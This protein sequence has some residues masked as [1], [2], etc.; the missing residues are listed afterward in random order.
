MTI[1]SHDALITE[2]TIP[3]NHLDNFIWRIICFNSIGSVGWK[4]WKAAEM[5]ENADLGGTNYLKFVLEVPPLHFA[6]R[7]A[8][9]S[10]CSSKQISSQHAYEGYVVAPRNIIIWPIL[11]ISAY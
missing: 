10:T 9:T 7:S 8:P 2:S 11:A 6:A 4:H 1:L 3:Y 5:P